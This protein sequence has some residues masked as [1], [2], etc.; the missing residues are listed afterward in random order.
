[1][2]TKEKWGNTVAVEKDLRRTV[3]SDLSNLNNI[4]G[5]QDPN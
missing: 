3:R 5:G 2:M 4:T 1:M